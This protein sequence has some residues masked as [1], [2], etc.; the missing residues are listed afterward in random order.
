MRLQAL[1]ENMPYLL[2]TRGSM[3]T[4]I[5][6]VVS[7]SRQKAAGGLFFC[8]PGARFDAHDYAPQAVANGC[9]ALVVDHFVE[10]DVPQVRVT[11]VRAAMSRMAAAFYGHPAERMKFIGVTGTKGKT[12]T[13]YM[14]K[15]ICEQAGYKCGLIGTTG[16][17]IG[18][19]R[20]KSNYTT[21]DPIDLQRD[22][23]AMADEGVE[24]VVMEVSAH[25]IDMHRLDGMT[26]EVGCYT[27]LSQ[28]H[29]DYFGTMENYFETKKRFFTSGMVRNATVNVDEETSEQVLADLTV[30]HLTFGIAANADLFARDIEINEDG[31]SFDLQLQ[32]M[33]SIPIHLRMTGMFNVYNALAAASCALVLGV[34][35]ENIRDGLW[36]MDSVP[37]R[38]EMLPTQTP[39]RVILDYSHSPDALTNILKTV[40][41]FARKRVIALF[42]CGGDRDKGKRPIMGEIGGRMADLCIL[43][44]DNPRT[45]DPM[46]IL[47]AIEEGIKPTRKPYEV[48]ENRREAIRHAMEIA[49]EGDIIVLCGKGHETYQEINGVKHPFDE[50]VVVQELLEEL[51]AQTANT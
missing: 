49:G 28:D 39:Y 34:S 15:A 14:I 43:T 5:L 1:I 41:G 11:N 4:E 26:F 2:E 9:V 19:K 25:A 22:L 10:A 40:R 44:S 42:G 48:I 21:P 16:N 38:I 37:G 6:A 12:T 35:I 23:R 3:D 36:N 32:G 7:D 50:K 13:T 17:M 31:V 18:K 33:H 46:T 47:A 30:P 8:I 27:N 45:E 51:R 24:V 29:L 20:I